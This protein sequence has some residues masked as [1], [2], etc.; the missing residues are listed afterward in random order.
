MTGIPFTLTDGL[1]A[2]VILLSGLFAFFRGFVREA[3]AI[4]AWVGAVVAALYGFRYARPI[5]RQLISVDTIADAT[6]G[7]VP[8]IVALI[9]LSVIS[10]ALARRVQDSVLSAVDR[11]LGFLFGLV[12]GAVVVC[13]ALLVVNWAV[14]KE[15]RPE[16]IANAR[17]LPTI[18]IGA[19]WLLN[20]LP[21]EVKSDTR[22][23]A[24]D[25][26]RK[27]EA[28]VEEK[29]RFDRLVNPQPQAN[30]GAQEA[31]PGYNAEQRRDLDVLIR[32]TQ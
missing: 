11:S 25:A 17:S 2:A 23:T 13:L 10:N 9:V 16:W 12:R 29:R 20:L 14:P 24:D 1:V 27:I 28:A 18:E 30:P 21:R 26:R 22:A 15:Q 7:I 4:G 6:A 32:T 19:Q 5:A 3:L 8:F 31:R